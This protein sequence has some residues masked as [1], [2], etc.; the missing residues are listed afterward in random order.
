MALMGGGS[1]FF[2]SP[3]TNVIMTAV[4]PDQRGMAAGARTMLANT[5]QMLS[6]A[7]AF[8]LVLAHIPQDVMMKVFIYGGGMAGNPAALAT[9][10]HGL[11]LAFII[12]CAISVVAA[13]ASAAQPAHGRAIAQARLAPARAGADG[14]RDRA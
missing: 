5:G 11:H 7:I 8:P 9:F 10:L 2:S 6:V 13:V 4:R 1:G 3:N 14:G 12:S